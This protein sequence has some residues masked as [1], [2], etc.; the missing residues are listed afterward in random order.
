VEARKHNPLTELPRPSVYAVKVGYR[1]GDLVTYRSKAM[2]VS[3]LVDF[4]VAL[5]PGEVMGRC[6]VL[7]RNDWTSGVYIIV[8]VEEIDHPK[9]CVA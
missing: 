6:Y 8:P 7:R 1:V 5:Y 4:S 9:F 2:L 3:A